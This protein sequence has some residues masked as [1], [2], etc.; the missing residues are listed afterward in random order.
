MTT[1]IASWWNHIALLL[2]EHQVCC[3]LGDNIYSYDIWRK[4]SSSEV[5]SEWT[6][7]LV[8]SWN[9]RL[10]GHI[11]FFN[12]FGFSAKG[13][14]LNTSGLFTEQSKD[15]ERNKKVVRAALSFLHPPFKSTG[16]PYKMT[17]DKFQIRA[18]TTFELIVVRQKQVLADYDFSPRQL[19]SHFLINQSL[20]W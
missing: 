13:R 1:L 2:V 8:S 3:S 19:K 4:H 18:T 6:I 12:S 20:D 9:G 11:C 5:S 14:N 15:V 16:L 10:G 7:N 17:F